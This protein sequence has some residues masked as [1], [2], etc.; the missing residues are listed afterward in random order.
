MRTE[1]SWGGRIGVISAFVGA[2][3]WQAGPGASP[4]SAQSAVL[5]EVSGD[6][7]RLTIKVDGNAEYSLLSLPSPPRLVIDL[8]GV[9]HGRPKVVKYESAKNLRDVRTSQYAPGENPTTRIVFDLWKDVWFQSFP[10][11]SDIVIVL[12]DIKAPMADKPYFPEPEGPGLLRFRGRLRD[13]AGDPMT[14]TFLLRFS[15]RDPGKGGRGV[16]REAI[17]V[18]ASQGFCSAVLG[19]SQPLPMEA[20][21][22]EYAFSV[23]PPPGAP[24]MV[25]GLPVTQPLLSRRH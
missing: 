12:S 14:G 21:S 3:C 15:L 7:D 20:F 9:S 10:Q 23:E 5:R 8:Y 18:R 11:G 19:R 25:R 17:Y 2:F 13:Y 22:E 4:C 6:G 1:R 24:W 16:W